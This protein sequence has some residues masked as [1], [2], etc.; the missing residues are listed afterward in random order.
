MQLYAPER[1]LHAFHGESLRVVLE[2]EPS[3]GIRDDAEQLERFIERFSNLST[4]ISLTTTVLM[5]STR[6]PRWLP[7]AVLCWN[8]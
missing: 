5:P 6:L 8:F 3:F 1:R 7:A 2:L 4:S